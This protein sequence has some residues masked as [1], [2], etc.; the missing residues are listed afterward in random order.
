MV[1]R[2]PLRLDLIRHG[3]AVPHSPDGDASRPLTAAGIR[4]VRRLGERFA[5]EGWRP[6][7]VLASPYERAQETALLL[8]QMTG[9][10][11]TLLPL[12]DLI[13][14]RGPEDLAQ[15]VARLADGLAHVVLVG[16]Q[17][18]LGSLLL[19]LAD[20]EAALSPGFAVRL[21][22]EPSLTRGSARLVAEYRPAS[23]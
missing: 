1:E 18:L 5:E 6:D 12:A 8:V 21:E 2:M 22:C 15:A 23:R 14:D 13:P 16:H 11:P 20:A 19:H 10:T 4:A 9:T 3:E 17:P 7:L